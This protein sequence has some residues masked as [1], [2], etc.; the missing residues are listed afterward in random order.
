MSSHHIDGRAVVS[1]VDLYRYVCPVHASRSHLPS[2]GLV[3][4]LRAKFTDQEIVGIGESFVLADQANSAWELL[5][6]LGKNLLGAEITKD[7]STKGLI[8]DVSEWHP[9]RNTDRGWQRSAKLA[10]EMALLDLKLKVTGKTSADIW[11][12]RGR[13]API[14]TSATWRLPKDVPLNEIDEVLSRQY[15]RLESFPTVKVRLSGSIESDLAWLK[16]LGQV[17]PEKLLWI[18]SESTNDEDDH[19]AATRI[20][21]LMAQG[22]LPSRVFFELDSPRRRPLAAKLIE[23]TF[24]AQL[25]GRSAASKLQEAVDRQLGVNGTAE[26]GKRLVVVAGAE[27]GTAGQLRW[28]NRGWPVGAVYLS[29]PHWGSLLRLRDAA[30]LAKKLDPAA[31]VILGGARGSRI[32]QLALERLAAAIPEID[33]Y[34]PE[35]LSSKWP[36]LLKEEEL[37][38][39]RGGFLT[40]LDASELARYADRFVFLPEARLVQD[41]HDRNRYPNHPLLWAPSGFL[42]SLLLETEALQAGFRTRRFDRE[43]FLAEGGSSG[44]VIGFSESEFPTTS[45]A[46]SVITVHKGVTRRM[47]ADH[48]LPVPEGR[49]FPSNEGDSAYKMGLELGFPLVVKPAAGS[50]GWGVTTGISTAD[51]LKLA[52]DV[53]K[54]SRYGDTGIIIERHVS[55]RDYRIIATAEKVVSVV[56]RDPASVVGDGVHTV[57]ELVL[58]ANIARRQNP[59]LGKRLLIPLDE[60]ADLPLQRQG[61]TR[62]SIPEAGQKVILSTVANVSQGGDSYEVLDETHETILE[63]AQRA[64]AALPGLAY[65]GLDVLMEDH[66]VA[67]SD[68]DVYIIE[69]NPKP[70]QTMHHFPMYGPPRN[71]SEFLVR[72]ALKAH[73]ALPSSTS[74][75]QLTVDLEVTGRVHGVGYK[76]WFARTASQLGI[77]GWVTDVPDQ[78]SVRALIQGTPA[79]VGLMLRLAFSGPPK[80]R[81]VETYSTPVQPV[82]MSGFVMKT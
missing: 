22:E 71:V 68:Q 62:E 25:R 45:A 81:V 67:V 3:V 28:L 52:I 61:L 69:V 76:R 6:E 18:Q 53:V 14:L 78:D 50:K 10:V 27:S 46:A 19:V 55:G 23:R 47:L 63:M 72:E 35:E 57:E 31:T 39:S 20:A 64:V 36:V 59:H 79:Q 60:R 74:M 26:Q 11:G 37:D 75:E 56:R 49:F 2:F 5:T 40:S 70:V 66:R 16:K 4:R 82:K 24:I 8:A 7:F 15:S 17:F 54:T 13:R 9:V 32:T 48:G 77:V 34:L 29:L 51:E 73:K 80:A 44:T 33:M 12:G 1:R 41:E 38:D 43:F 21:E 42:R 30:L 65:A 58:M